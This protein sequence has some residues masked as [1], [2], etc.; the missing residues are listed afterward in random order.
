MQAMYME[1]NSKQAMFLPLQQKVESLLREEENILHKKRDRK[2]N[3][4][5]YTVTFIN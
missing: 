1:F 4:V 2:E 3:L 5:K